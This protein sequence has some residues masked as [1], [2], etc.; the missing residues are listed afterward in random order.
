MR[1]TCQEIIKA[2]AAAG[3]MAVFGVGASAQAQEE[4]VLGLSG[5]LSG[6]AGTLYTPMV[7]GINIYFQRLNDA[8]GIKG[9]KVRI[10]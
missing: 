6:P 1:Q 9:R 5:A 2:A 7:E 4:Y 8:G 3:A 10:V